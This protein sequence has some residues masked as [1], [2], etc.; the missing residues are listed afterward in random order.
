[1][2]L[3]LLVA[4]LICPAAA[5]R[6]SG[7]PVAHGG[8]DELVLVHVP[9]NFGHI[10]EMAVLLP[11]LPDVREGFN[12]GKN[13]LA[14]DFTTMNIT[15]KIVNTLKMFKP[16]AEV[17]GHMNPDLNV[18]SE[19][20]GCPMY[21]TPQKYWPKDLAEKYFA[22]KTRFGMLRDPYERLNSFFRG[23]FDKYGG[24]YPEYFKTCDVNSAV[25]Q[26]MKEVLAS[27]NA[28][29]RGCTFIPQA[30]YFE[31]EYGI[32]LPVDNRRVPDS[33][34]EVFAKYGYKVHLKANQMHHVRGC[35]NAWAGDFDQETKALVKQVYARDFELLCK[36]FNYCDDD[37]EVCIPGVPYMCPLDRYEW[38]E[39][40]AHFQKKSA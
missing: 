21:Y 2:R 26:M 36:H 27:K 25:K 10:A 17:W 35:D 15:W 12:G 19:V 4:L 29:M 20:T 39:T 31:G 23:N 3:W 32:Q 24:A 5:L 37:E 9:Y 22:G 18:I 6:A 11:F 40:E 1:M 14:N 33:M 13:K 7:R 8:P 16:H 28:F 38:N 30:E 34:N